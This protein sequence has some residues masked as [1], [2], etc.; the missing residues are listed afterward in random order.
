MLLSTSGVGVVGYLLLLP[1][2]LEAKVNL[3][4]KLPFPFYEIALKVSNE[5]IVC[6]LM[7]KFAEKIVFG[8]KT[9]NL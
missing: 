4:R 3:F 8:R 7:D 5:T 1:K 9:N 6:C 2:M